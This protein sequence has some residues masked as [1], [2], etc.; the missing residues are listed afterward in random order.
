MEHLFKLLNEFLAA[1]GSAAKR[2]QIIDTS[3]VAVPKQRNS[4]EENRHARSRKIALLMAGRKQRN[5][6]KMLM[7]AGSKRT[8]NPIMSIRIMSRLM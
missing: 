5:G 6:K 2:G 1:N 7:P 3:I 8:E 4:R